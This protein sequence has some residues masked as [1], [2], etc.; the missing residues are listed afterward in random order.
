MMDPEIFCNL[1]EL[2]SPAISD[3]FGPKFQFS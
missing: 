2:E 1:V 3:F